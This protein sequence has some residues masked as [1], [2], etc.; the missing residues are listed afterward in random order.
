M[1]S[2]KEFIFGS[3]NLM[4]NR[5]AVIFPVSYDGVKYKCVVSIEVLKDY[6]N[7]THSGFLEA[8]ENNKNQINEIVK[9]QIISGNIASDNEVLITTD[10]FRDNYLY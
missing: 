9:N 3:P 5:T 6:F 2:E 4:R 7:S 8:Y 1:L 10:V